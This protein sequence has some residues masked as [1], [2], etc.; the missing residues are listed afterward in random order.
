MTAP[1]V[2]VVGDHAAD[3]RR[4]GGRRRSRP[5]FRARSD[6]LFRPCGEPSRSPRSATETVAPHA[7][8]DSRSPPSP[9]PARL[10]PGGRRDPHARPRPPGCRLAYQGDGDGRRHAA[11]PGLAVVIAVSGADVGTATT[12]AAG[13][14][15]VPFK[16]ARG[17]PSWRGFRHRR[18]PARRS[19]SPSARSSRS[20]S[21]RRSRSVARPSTSA[22]SRRRGR[23]VCSR[24]PRSATR[25]PVRAACAS[26]RARRASSSPRRH[27]AACASWSRCPPWRPTPRP[28]RSAA[29]RRM[30]AGSP[31]ARRRRRAR[32]AARPREAR[33]PHA[34]I[35]IDAVAPGNRLDRRLPEGVQAAAHLRVRRRR[36][37]Q[38]AAGP[39]DPPPLQGPEAAHRDRQDAPDPARRPE[40]PRPR[41][42]ADLDRRHGQHAG[43]Q[44]EDPLEGPLHDDLAGLGDP[45]PDDDVQGQRVRH[46]RLRAG[47][48]HAASHG[49]ARIPMWAADWLYRQS[50]VGETVY[51]YR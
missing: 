3:R 24:A 49:C 1:R 29:S 46:P 37:A 34:G 14:F 17:G 48:A 32:A 5:T 26:A 30:A 33:V 9:R 18:R 51:V 36:L 15:A 47:A 21:A 28:P 50:P 19:R 13:H 39:P 42:P 6:L 8:A 4:R 27:S 38:F 16:A 35:S 31:R 43:G 45:L 10:C 7:T 11:D 40:R 25:V 12:D 41:H 20:A 44:V 2:G 23:A 22:C